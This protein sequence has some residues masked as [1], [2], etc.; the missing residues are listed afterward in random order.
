MRSLFSRAFNKP[1][2]FAVSARAAFFSLALAVIVI[3]LAVHS[4][5]GALA[6]DTRD[7]LGDVLWAGMIALLIGAFS[8]VAPLPI[9]IAI[10]VAVCFAVELS[11]L[12]HTPSLDAAR[13]TT[14][15]QLTL[16]SGF[17]PRDLAAYVV[18]VL[19]VAFLERTRRRQ[20]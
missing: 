7:V 9:R 8:P 5:G 16:G 14:I 20:V 10:A 6:P 17:D 15:G 18:G 1:G 19:V 2:F 4:F 3:G 13:R 12:Y 11:Q